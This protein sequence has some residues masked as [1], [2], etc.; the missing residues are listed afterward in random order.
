LGSPW[1]QVAWLRGPLDVCVAS[2]A[3]SPAAAA[4][5]NLPTPLLVALVVVGLESVVL[6][7]MG[8]LELVSLD[9]ARP[10]VALTAGLFFLA[11]AAFLAFFTWRLARLESWARAPLVMGQLIQIPVGLS[12][13]GGDTRFVTVALLAAAGVALVG[14][15][16]PASIAAIEA[17]ED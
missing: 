9:T 13:W 11:Y 4:R 2:L 3:V 12:Y 17:A 16:H 6:L 7:V 15:F 1:S 5:S 8:V 14:I 10:E